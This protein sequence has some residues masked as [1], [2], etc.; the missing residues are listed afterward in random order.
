MRANHWSM[1]GSFEPRIY[2][3]EL[4]RGCAWCWVVRFN[5]FASL[6][7]Q[8]VQGLTPMQAG[9]IILPAGLSM[10]F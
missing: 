8:T 3:G 2:R 5:L 1:F 7:V 6:F 9:A 10:I 4:S